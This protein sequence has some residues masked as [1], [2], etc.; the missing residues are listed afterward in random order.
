MYR[1]QKPRLGFTIVELLIVVIVI[2]ILA[3]LII[4][5]YNRISSD[6][7]ETSMKADLETASE[8]LGLDYLN[9]GNYPVNAAAANSGKGLTSSNGTTLTYATQPYGYCVSA[10][11]TKSSKQFVY[12]SYKDTVVEGTCLSIVSTFAGSGAGSGGYADGTGTAAQ[13]NNP[14]DIEIDEAGNLYVAEDYNNRIRKITPSG[15][16]TTLAGSG[17]AG[18]GDGIGTAAQ[19]SGPAG[20]ILDSS[21]TLYVADTDNHRIRK[22]TPAGVVTTVAGSG[23]AGFANNTGTAAQFNRPYDVALDSSNNLYV[24]DLDNDRVRKI[25]PAGVVTTFAGSGVAGSTD[26]TGVAAT[27]NGP[28]GIAVDSV[29]NVYVATDAGHRIRKI[30]PGAVVTTL[31]GSTDGYFDGTGAAARFSWP[32]GIAIDNYDNLYVADSNNYRIRKIT[33]A[34][35]V[36]TVTGTGASGMING[37]TGVATFDYP[38]GVAIND[39]GTIMYIADTWNDVIRKIEL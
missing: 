29:D 24:A 5:G 21:G 37:T 1:L 23:V 16:V 27:F 2:A 20:L 7:V 9:G 14:S 12:K 33:S 11:N 26:A 31:A 18:F 13:F 6:A 8:T 22:I 30:T 15:V 38:W 36:T 10:S 39:Q 34:G 3:S 19:F 17:V 28:L 25:T 4:V 32:Q 35:V